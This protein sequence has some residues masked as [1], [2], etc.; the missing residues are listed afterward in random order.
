MISREALELLISTAQ[1][2][3]RVE[4]LDTS[5]DGRVAI[6]D[7][8]G[9]ISEVPIPPP[10][11][12][13]RVRSLADLIAFAAECS[14]AIVWHDRGSVV[15]ILDDRD[16]RD[17]V[18][19][20]LTRFETFVLLSAQTGADH[21]AVHDQ[22]GFVRLLRDLGADSAVIAPFRRLDW[23]AS[24][25]VTGEHGQTADRLG[26]EIQGS[27]SG[28][29]LPEDLIIMTPVYA[30]AGETEL[31]SVRCRIDC[32]VLEQRLALRPLPGEIDAAYERAQDSIRE[33]L[34][35]GL[36]DDARIYYGSP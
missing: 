33:R 15:L 1:Q 30:Q 28:T 16:R 32:Q 5:P 17:R 25:R 34:R 21:Q 18:T 27:I 14:A 10:E 36:G 11:R 19:F 23:Q 9:T 35:K 7:E 31:Q 2:A 13:H 22:R 26:R 8:G 4:R 6:Y 3:K 20:E 29:D 24:V 12:N